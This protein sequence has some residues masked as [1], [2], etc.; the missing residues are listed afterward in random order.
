MASPR[1]SPLMV[2]LGAIFLLAT[3]VFAASAV[4]GVDLGTEYI[5]AALVKPGKPLDIVLTKD[6]RRKEI[7]AVALKPAKGGPKKGEYPE[8]A[9]G[10]DAMAISSR[11]PGEVYPNLKTLLGLPVEDPIVHEYAASHPALQLQSHPVRGTAAFKSNAVSP[12]EDAWMVEELLAMQLQNLQKNAEV[13]AGDGS[14]VRSI[15]LTVPPFY[16][17]EEKRAVQLAAELAGLKVLS[18]ISDGLAVGLNYATT[19]QFPNIKD[20]EKP[21]HHLVFDMGAGSTKATVMKFQS[22]TVKDVG[23]FNKTIQEVQVLGTGWDRTLGGDALNL[24]IVDDMVAKFVESKAAQKLSV[25]S[26]QIKSHGRAMA[27]LLK[28]AERAR[29]VLSANQNTGSTFEGLYEDID[30]KYKISRA[31]FETMAETHINRVGVVLKDA[32]QLSGLDIAD[33]TSVILFGGASRTPFVQKAL[34]DI[35]GSAEKIRS[36]VNSD[37]AA[38][39]GAGF[40]AAELSPSFRVKEIKIIEGAGYSAGI[41][42]TNA[43]GKIQ[44]QRLW[45][46]Q[47]P[48]GAAPK[49]VTFTQLDD[50]SASFYQQVGS[51]NRDVTSLTTKNLTATVAALKESYPSCTDA[52]IQFKLGVKLASNNGEVVVTKAAIECEAEVV[53]KEGFVDG[54]KNILGFGKKDQQPLKKDGADEATE[55][56]EEELKEDVESET[57][58]SSSTSSS[59]SS[60]T[61]G[62]AATSSDDAKTETKKK[63]LVSIPIEVVLE[64]TGIPDLSKEE[65]AK[66]KDRL[67]AFANSDKARI[68]REEALNQLEGYTYK[69]RDLIDREAFVAKSTE[70]ERASIAQKASAASE[71]IYEDGVK[72]AKEEFKA[73]LKEI[74]NLV[75]P[76]QKRVDEAA[77]RPGLLAELKSSLTQTGAYIEKMR[78]QIDEYDEWHAS[79]SASSTEST[80][81]STTTEAASETPSGDFEGLEDDEGSET[82][83]KTMDDVIEER[84]P[85]PPLNTREDID[86]LEAVYK[87]VLEWITDVE[88]RQEALGE[89]ADPVMLVKDLKAFSDKLGKAGVDLAMKGT[90][91]FKKDNK[92][93]GKKPTKKSS[94]DGDDADSKFKFDYK[95]G[96]KPFSQ[97]DIED[98]L[99]KIKENDPD[100]FEEIKEEIKSKEPRH[101][102]L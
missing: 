69:V 49:E 58:S 28:D 36:N 80:E 98:L 42:W 63:E 100:A 83:E 33:I 75:N 35:V 3:N 24:L 16:S 77:E 21:E 45:L 95:P 66:S 51:V 93:S 72:A 86:A 11:F 15:V 97:E 19:R 2:L 41:K 92:K 67:K 65:L 48:L 96:D 25:T 7:S 76:I 13:A 60:T 52:N 94:G 8:R 6:S 55:G 53:Q 32:L 12:E 99:K 46:A 89:T 79:R 73:K 101:D 4:L 38:V 102:E 9:Y 18:L 10:A 78:Q 90:K 68:Q 1:A 5:K 56:S 17:T 30:F 31:E 29:H 43:N 54:V 27:K 40:R 74:Q 59:S 91:N 62:S 50:F 57:A 47:S 20:G 87:E 44:R 22:R 84:G 39:F 23:K 85:V 14:S 82:K 64:K 61:S 81:P 70:D 26:E 37:E 88:P 34:E 71:W